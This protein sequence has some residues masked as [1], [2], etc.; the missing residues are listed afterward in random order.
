MKFFIT[1]N[2]SKKLNLTDNIVEF[3]EVISKFWEET[4]RCH[5]NNGNG[6]EEFGDAWTF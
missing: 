3:L 1:E 6:F 4:I 2:I 5:G